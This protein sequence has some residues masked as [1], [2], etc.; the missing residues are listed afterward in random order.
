[1]HPSDHTSLGRPTCRRAQPASFLD[2]TNT[3]LEPAHL[4]YL[5]ESLGAHE[6]DRPNLVVSLDIGCVVCDSVSDAEVNEFEEACSVQRWGTK[7]KQQWR[8][9]SKAGLNDGK[10]VKTRAGTS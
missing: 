5:F 8:T 10:K 1:M 9:S 4:R 7:Y 2:R 6:V 3:H